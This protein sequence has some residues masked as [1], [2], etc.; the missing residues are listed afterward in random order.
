MLQ[1]EVQPKS[2]RF[3]SL[4]PLSLVNAILRGRADRNTPAR[5]S[6]LSQAGERV[7]SGSLNELMDRQYYDTLSDRLLEEVHRIY[8]PAKVHR[9]LDHDGTAASTGQASTDAMPRGP[10]AEAESSLD[11]CDSVPDSGTQEDR[12]RRGVNSLSQRVDDLCKWTWKACPGLGLRLRWLSAWLSELRGRDDEAIE[13]YKGFLDC[14][15]DIESP[16][17]YDD[18]PLPL[19]LREPQLSLLAY[20]NRSVLILRQSAKQ[21][22]EQYTEAMKRIVYLAIWH[23]LP[24]ACLSLMNVINMA[25]CRR[26]PSLVEHVDQAVADAFN[27]L[28]DYFNKKEEENIEKLQNRSA[29]EELA[30]MDPFFESTHYWITVFGN[31]KLPKRPFGRSLD[32]VTKG[33]ARRYRFEEYL[34]QQSLFIKSYEEDRVTRQQVPVDVRK[35]LVLWETGANLLVKGTPERGPHLPI[36]ERHQRYAEA[37]TLL[38]PRDVSDSLEDSDGPGTERDSSGDPVQSPPPGDSMAGAPE[39]PLDEVTKLI[40]SGNLDTAEERIRELEARK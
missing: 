3:E 28:R 35:E 24:G 22:S 30:K 18:S 37:A 26:D 5:K 17:D 25:W 10:D 13:R 40:E 11:E 9:V 14:V 8:E 23:M 6:I 4:D 21:S 12:R 34:K 39:D 32:P 19:S 16:S 33:T 29:W 38:Y 20:N 2:G 31:E 1:I 36:E 27:A 15:D 7:E